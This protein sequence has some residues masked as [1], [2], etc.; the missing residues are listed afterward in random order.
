MLLQ[1]YVCNNKSLHTLTVYVCFYACSNHFIVSL[2]GRKLTYNFE[3]GSFV[4]SFVQSKSSYPFIGVTDW[5]QADLKLR[6]RAGRR[7]NE[8]KKS[9][10]ERTK[11]LLQLTAVRPLFQSIHSGSF[12]EK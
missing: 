9:E 7:V 2:S 8:M 3:E 1:L 11:V 12:G 6:R 4:R 10:C 5:E